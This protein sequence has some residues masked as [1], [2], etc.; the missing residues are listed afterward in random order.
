MIKT[1]TQEHIAARNEIDAILSDMRKNGT[2]PEKKARCQ[3]ILDGGKLYE[4][5]VQKSYSV[6]LAKLK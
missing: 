5:S 6:Q 1:A 4:E 3:S 2:T